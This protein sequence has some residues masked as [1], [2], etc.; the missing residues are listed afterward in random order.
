MFPMIHVDKLA[1]SFQDKK[2]GEVHALDHI[3]F[4]VHARE[5]LALIGL[6]GAGT[7]T[8]LTLLD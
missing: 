1:K 8:F 4:D 7:T 2:R 5:I 6:Y 3:S